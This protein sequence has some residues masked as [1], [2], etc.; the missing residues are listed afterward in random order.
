[1]VGVGDGWR[2]CTWGDDEVGIGNRHVLAA[3]A[4][5][6][7]VRELGVLLR[8][9]RSRIFLV[10]RHLGKRKMECSGVNRSWVGVYVACIVSTVAMLCGDGRIPS[11]CRL[12]PRVSTRSSGVYKRL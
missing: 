2:W 11:R 1:V 12:I 6:W 8:N 5:G 3:L 9:T 10:V 7:S 4:R